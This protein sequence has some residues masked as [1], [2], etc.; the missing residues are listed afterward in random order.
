MYGA[1]VLGAPIA[2][3]GFPPLFGT[4]L[5]LARLSCPRVSV[6]ST[7]LNESFGI[8]RICPPKPGWL[9]NFAYDCQPLMSHG[10]ILSVCV[11]NH[12]TR[13]PLKNHGVLDDTKEGW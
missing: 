8:H 5:P 1:L 7:S 2:A 13:R 6:L 10:S 9:L 3:L 12:C 11:G 4:P